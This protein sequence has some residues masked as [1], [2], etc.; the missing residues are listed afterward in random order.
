[1]FYIEHGTLS[2][3]GKVFDAKVYQYVSAKD[4]LST[5]KMSIEDSEWMRDSCHPNG[6]FR[7]NRCYRKHFIV[8]NFDLLCDGCVN[9]LRNDFPDSEP[10]KKLLEWNFDDSIISD[11]T[12]L[13]DTLDKVFK[14]DVL[15]YDSKEIE[16]VKDLFKNNGNLQVKYKDSSQGEKPFILNVYQIS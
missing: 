12:K 8:N 13:R 1:M 6:Y 2:T 14:S 9:T 3:D 16:I 7:C 11:R 4:T 5:L 15:F 10:T